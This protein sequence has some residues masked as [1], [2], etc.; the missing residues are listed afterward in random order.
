MVDTERLRAMT[1]FEVRSLIND[2]NFGG[3][4]QR[5]DAEMLEIW[6]VAVLETRALLEDW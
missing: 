5:D 1:P 2:G 4:Y 6:N 3:R